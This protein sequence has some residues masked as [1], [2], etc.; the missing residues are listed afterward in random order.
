VSSRSPA[1]NSRGATLLTWSRS[2]LA[3][4]QDRWRFADRLVR[5]VDRYL[6]VQGSLLS[7]GMTYYGFLA[8]FPLV[9]V[10][11]GVTSVLSRVVPS[12]DE[13]VRDQ[14]AAVMPNVDVDAV[15]NASLTVGLIG[16]AVMLYAGVRWVGALRRSLTVLAGR[17]PRSVPY[18][19]GIVGDAAV[20]A[21][22]GAAVLASIA[23]S[24]VTQLATGLLSGLLGTGASSHLVRVATL[25]AALATDLA[26]GWALYH[27]VDDPRLRGRRLLVTAA[28]AGLGFEVLKQLAAVI[29]AASSHNVIYGTFAATVGVLIWMSYLSK[30]I[31]FVG[32]WALVQEVAGP[33]P[34]TGPSQ[35]R[36]TA[37]GDGH[38]AGEPAP[39][40]PT[41]QPDE[42]GPDRDEAT[43]DAG[44]EP[45]RR[46]QA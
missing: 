26:I 16:L 11:L 4:V 2:L 31:L 6:D 28:V 5:T 8:L 39:L 27:V 45:Q 20:L 33:Q 24:L 38:P 43:G 46:G 18:L 25:V 7:A 19:R 34:P 12:V 17:P 44:R 42:P 9:A 40:P 41:M 30:W 1:A 13:T 15:V 37:G 14:V 36:A 29:I 21:L 32:A 22:L 3:R 10:G 35:P 23:L